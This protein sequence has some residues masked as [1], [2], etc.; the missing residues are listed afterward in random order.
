MRRISLPEFFC[1]L[2]I[3]IMEK[4]TFVQMSL[5]Q[6]PLFRY[7]FQAISCKFGESRKYQSFVPMHNLSYKLYY[8]FG[9]NTDKKHVMWIFWI[10][11]IIILV[12]QLVVFN[13]LKVRPIF[14]H[15]VFKSFKS[16]HNLTDSDS[17][18]VIS[19]FGSHLKIIHRSS[20]SCL[21]LRFCK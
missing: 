3:I 6:Q 9:R 2:F 7:R 21:P 8:I 4:Q 13:H 14:H 11:V 12:I 17:T 18:K 19:Y 5:V 10:V 16:H 1:A 15:V 20:G